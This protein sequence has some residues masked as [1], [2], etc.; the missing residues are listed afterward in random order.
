M[1]QAK[2]PSNKVNWWL[3]AG[4]IVFKATPESEDLHQA[5]LNAVIHDKSKHVPARGL[6]AAQRALQINF[7]KK[8]EGNPPVIV[9]VIIN[10]L[11]HL[12]EM[13]PEEFH[14]VPEGMQEVPTEQVH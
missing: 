8:F 1:R 14:A 11:V 12:G 13:T 9:D 5:F 6:G 2:K 3:V 4:Q 10:N 7:H